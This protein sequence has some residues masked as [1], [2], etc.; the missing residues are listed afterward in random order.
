MHK[1][2]IVTDERGLTNIFLDDQEVKG[3]YEFTLLQSVEERIPKLI[4]GLYVDN[5]DI[6][7]ANV[8]IEKNGVAE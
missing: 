3:V 1:V 2:R 7:M 8:N 4:M 5:M 6:E